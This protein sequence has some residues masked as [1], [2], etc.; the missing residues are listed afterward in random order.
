MNAMRFTHRY[1]L[2]FV[3]R[4]FICFNYND[5]SRKSKNDTLKCPIALSQESDPN[6]PCSE[7]FYQAGN[8]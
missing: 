2:S 6:E 1:F 3:W 8:Y 5:Y 7:Q 4:Y